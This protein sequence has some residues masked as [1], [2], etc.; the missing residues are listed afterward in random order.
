MCDMIHLFMWH[1]SFICVTWLIH[2]CDRTH[3]Y[4]WQDSFI[5]VTWLIHMYDIYMC[6]RTHS[7][8][9]HDSFINVT[10]LVHT[11]RVSFKFDMTHSDVTWL[12]HKWHD[13][14]RCDQTHSYVWHNS[15]TRHYNITLCMDNYLH[16]SHDTHT[17]ARIQLFTRVAW[18]AHTHTHTIESW[19][20]SFAK[21]IKI[22][23]DFST[24]VRKEHAQE[25]GVWV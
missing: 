9:W 25:K 7:Y 23:H 20:M 8:V 11:S 3:L 17:H 5:C 10:R 6:D 21:I 16:E 18:H 22:F 19:V 13:S 24:Q 1:D 4:V 15:I 12:I 14:F 2:M